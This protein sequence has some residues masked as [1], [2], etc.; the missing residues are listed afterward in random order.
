MTRWRTAYFIAIN[1]ALLWVVTL[2]ATHAGIVSYHWLKAR[3]GPV[4]MPPEA[5]ATYSSRT[6]AESAQRGRASLALRFRAQP[7]G[8]LG[9]DHLTA[10]VG[11]GDQ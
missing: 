3:Y 5:R 10:R 1:T 2:V 4:S 11:H 7:V 8:G 6:P 9:P